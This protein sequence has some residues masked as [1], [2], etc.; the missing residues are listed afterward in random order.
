MTD[1]LTSFTHLRVHSHFTLLGAVAPISGL[2]ARA[3][4]D[5]LTHLALTD[6]NALYGVISFNRACSAAGVQPIVG[7]TL[8]VAGVDGA[9]GTRGDVVLLA[10]NADGYRSLCRLSS[11]LQ[12]VPDREALQQRGVPWQSL[13]ENRSGLFCLCGGRGSWVDDALRMGDD[14]SA[15]RVATALA[16]VFDAY[17]CLTVELHT[18]ADVQ[19]GRAT[20]ALA[21]R[22]GVRSAAAQP[23]HTL[24]AG[25][26][27]LLRLL[28]AIKRNVTLADLSPEDA[29]GGGDE[30][31]TVHWL[32]PGEMGQR[33][34][35]MPQALAA[36]GEIVAECQPSLPD[37]RPLWPALT[38]PKNE[39]PD[40]ALARLAQA[41]LHERFGHDPV[42]LARLSNELEA[43]GSHGFAPFF[44]LVADVVRF[45]RSRSIPVSTRGSV[46][47]SLVAYCLGITT[48]D[49]IANDLLFERFLN[50]ARTSLP[51][52]DL[53]FCSRRRDE[54]LD[55]VRRT[56]GA[57]RVALVATVNTF[58]PRSAVR[59]VGKAYGLSEDAIKQ[60]V[61]LLPDAWHPDPRRRVHS[62]VETLLRQIDDPTERLALAD[63]YALV[64]QPDHLSVH[65]GGVV[66][67][68]GPLTD[69]VPVQWASKGFLITQFDHDDVEAIGLPK[70][71]LLGIRALTVLADAAELV[72]THFDSTFTLNAIPMNDPA[73]AALLA[74]GD[75]VGVFQCES[76][77]AQ[78]TLRQ[79]RAATVRD[80]AVANAFFKP[81]PA[82][83][84]MAASFVR[85]YR[86]EEP[87]TFLHP[88]LAPILRPTQ[89]VLL[90]Q[91]QILR[92]ATEIAGLS[93]A[94]AEE[95]RKGMSK[96]RPEAIAALR[97]RFVSGCQRND[98]G[99]GFSPQQAATLWE[100]VQ[101]FA[102]YGFNQGHA[103][104]YADVSYR[105]AYLKA[106][107]PAAFLCARLADWG[108]FH[109]PA[110]YMAEAV[111]LGLKVHP[112]HINVSQYEFTLE[113]NNEGFALYMGLGQVRDLRHSAIADIVA[114][115]HEGPFSGPMDLCARVQLQAKELTHLVQCGALDGLG[116]SR[117]GLL[118]EMERMGREGMQMAFDFTVSD[119]PAE[120]PA[121][122]MAWEQHLLGYP[123]TV[124]PLDLAAPPENATPLAD[125]AGQPGRRVLIHAVRLPGWT[126]GKGYF[127]SDGRSYVMA[128]G[129]TRPQAWQPLQLSGRW[130]VDAWGGGCFRVEEVV[131][132]G[133]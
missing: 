57:E 32:S 85:R 79:L 78:R 82:T 36:V 84:G 7:M 33:F 45:A 56:Y 3:Q 10:R 104:A 25:E 72:Q 38:L 44:L 76:E 19:L 16:R 101:A 52:I 74:R 26:R 15:L 28:A 132:N 133:G 105:S 128:M 27:P 96:F 120:T 60:L 93:W 66:V 98:R 97:T 53:D 77:G 69:V 65:P 62:D 91:E 48:V 61:S 107:W 9:A 63:A 8:T 110:V 86:G 42:V 23:V 130:V 119:P 109:H 125:L 21:Q 88:A 49:P 75:A 24:R 71:D 18:P 1:P 2:V 111:R 80:L 11:L 34:Q 112:P 99:P 73:T 41:G 70:M 114:A 106:H 46:A 95:L 5:G 92:V 40:A 4:G 13:A 113:T 6:R 37:G 39:T 20:M 122:R 83:G 51:D 117:A 68:P 129:G 89:G 17:F 94:E 12:G 118:A 121:Q 131:A 108:G 35:A 116:A 90:F 58:Q 14:G 67:T 64:G 55:Y 31:R 30:T 43:I 126:G 123:L 100:Q 50:P 115:R 54:V 81:G 29:S 87:V 47:N 127:L 124:H 102:G 59:E 103:T 22:V